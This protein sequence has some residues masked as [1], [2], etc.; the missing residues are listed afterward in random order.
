MSAG[1]FKRCPRCS[2]LAVAL[3]PIR[4]PDRSVAER[5]CDA[6]VFD[7][8]HAGKVKLRRRR[9]AKHTT[10]KAGIPAKAVR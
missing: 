9:V 5:V 6:C 2:E 4:N 1:E 8:L 7:D 10:R 3:N